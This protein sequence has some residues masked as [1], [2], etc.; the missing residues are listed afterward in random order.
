MPPAV[1]LDEHRDGPPEPE[2][3]E[4]LLQEVSDLRRQNKALESQLKD[5]IA[6]EAATVEKLKEANVR[7]G[8]LR[9]PRP[10]HIW[11]GS[12]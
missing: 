7:D 4:A 3:S 1:Q 8:S 2:S 9:P 12:V 11:R 5:S 6:R 10:E